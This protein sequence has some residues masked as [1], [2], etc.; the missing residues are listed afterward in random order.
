MFI[1]LA[2]SLK[3][4]PLRNHRGFKDLFEEG[5]ISRSYNKDKTSKGEKVID[6]FHLIFE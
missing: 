1:Y 2:L 3:T 6:V 5:L 4:N